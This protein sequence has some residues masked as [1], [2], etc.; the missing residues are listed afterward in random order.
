M[1]YEHGFAVT[2]PWVDTNEDGSSKWN[3]SI[4]Y[5]NTPV[6]RRRVKRVIR[7]WVKHT[8]DRTISTYELNLL[9]K[10]VIKH[11]QEMHYVRQR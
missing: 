7:Q 8:M 1:K 10:R 6:D 9:M 11:T 2:I 3:N 4:V 5:T